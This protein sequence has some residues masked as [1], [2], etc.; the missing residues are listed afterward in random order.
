M[1]RTRHPLAGAGVSA[2]ANPG[3]A[4]GAVMQGVDTIVAVP[5]WYVNFNLDTLLRNGVT[6]EGKSLRDVRLADSSGTGWLTGR[7]SKLWT[8]VFVDGSVTRMT[9]ILQFESGTMDYWDLSVAPPQNSRCDVGGLQFGF[10]VDL[11]VA[12]VQQDQ[13]LPDDVKKRVTELLTYLGPGAFSIQHLFMDFENAV[14]SQYNPTVTV[15]PATMPP[16]ATAVFPV[17]MATYMRQLRAVGGNIL[18]YAITVSED[19]DLPAT[20]PPTSLVCVTNQYRGGPDGED[21]DPDLD[22]INYLM[23]TGGARLPANLRPYWGNFVVPAD[24]ADGLC[25]KVAMAKQLFV[26]QFLL[27]RLAPLVLTCWT[28]KDNSSSLDP[29]YTVDTGGFAPTPLGGSWSSGVRSGTS[30][31]G[32]AEA[33]YT[34][35]I[36]VDCAVTPGLNS[37]VITRTTDFDIQYTNWLGTDFRTWYN[38]PLTITIELIGV[39]D[40]RL[41]VSVSSATREPAP[42]AV[43]AEPYGWD[44]VRT[45]GSYSIWALV[46]ADMDRTIDSMVRLAMPTALLPDIKDTI[47]NCLNLDPFVFPGSAQLFMKDAA[48]SAAGDLLLGVQYKV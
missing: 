8:K 44:I 37:V 3:G 24:D 15:F 17:Y 23:M 19:A 2:S 26:Q 9:F 5:Q 47:E 16:A 4:S 1:T 40:G 42:E 39:S 6:A 10:D 20:F 27:P 28:F 38:I 31:H 34:M 43:Y 11:G 45:A 25:G 30:R 35:S 18:G 48:F 33:K 12:R 46:S 36:R 29:N 21:R 41:Q 32:G 13:T 22:T 7:I 14:L